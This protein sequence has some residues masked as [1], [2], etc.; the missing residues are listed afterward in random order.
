MPAWPTEEGKSPYAIWLEIIQA[1]DGFEKRLDNF[2]TDCIFISKGTFLDL[3][4]RKE[5]QKYPW[6]IIYDD[7]FAVVWQ[8]NE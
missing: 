4:L 8:K 1:Q 5:G 3:E 2:S 6:Q 7:D